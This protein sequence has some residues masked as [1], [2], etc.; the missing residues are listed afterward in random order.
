[1]TVR[2]YPRDM[3]GYGAK[4]PHPRWPGNARVAISIAL[5]Y[6]GGGER[7]IL[8]GDATSESIL[9]DIGFPEVT[10]A[11]SMLVES[12]FEYGSRRGV[13]RLLRILRE[14]DVRISLFG[15]ANALARNPEVAQAA[16]ADGH[17]IVSHGWRWIDY[18]GVS[19]SVEREHIR[20][21]ATRSPK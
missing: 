17:E 12:S 8:D 15:V 6:E 5:N 2:P 19:E 11:R 21:P 4:P 10:G 16:V 14:R 3:R 18:Q 9:T 20:W 1:M 13:W 7:S